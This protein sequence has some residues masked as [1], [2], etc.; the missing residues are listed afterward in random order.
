PSWATFDDRTGRLKGTPSSTDAGTTPPIKISASY[1]VGGKTR[2]VVMPEFTITVTAPPSTPTPPPTTTT[3]T[4][5]PSG[6]LTLSGT[7]QTSVTV[8]QG[9][10]FTPTVTTPYNSQ[11]TFWASHTPSW[12]TFDKTT[13][14][15]SGTPTS[16][17]AGTTPERK[18]VV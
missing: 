16:A 12:A 11:L 7:P 15:L 17:G 9:Y 8:G 4:P 1:S 18:S 14:R 10:S 5:T 6:S 2:W 13:G 3:P